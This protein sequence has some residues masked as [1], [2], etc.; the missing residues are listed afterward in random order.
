MSVMEGTGVVLTRNKQ[1][2]LNLIDV[3][4]IGAVT[5]NPFILSGLHH[6]HN[7]GSKPCLAF[8]TISSKS[9]IYS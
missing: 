3:P 7:E 2:F 9:F 6:P 4:K 8:A 1:S 5:V